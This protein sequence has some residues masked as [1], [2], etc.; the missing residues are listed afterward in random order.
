MMKILIAFFCI[1]VSFHSFAKQ[2]ETDYETLGNCFQFLN[3][4]SQNSLRWNLR[5][6]SFYNKYYKKPIPQMME[7]IHKSEISCKSFRGSEAYDKCMSPNLTKNQYDFWSG[8]IGAQYSLKIAKS[9]MD[10][11]QVEMICVPIFEGSK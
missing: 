8:S 4:K 3:Y 7:A 5:E 9:E 1:A 6:T 11:A 2:K 10:I